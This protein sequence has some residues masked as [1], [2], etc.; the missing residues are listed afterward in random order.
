VA[1]ADA[2]IPQPA[3]SGVV[4]VATPAGPDAG[5]RGAAGTNRPVTAARQVQPLILA[6]V[7]NP[8]AGETGRARN[9]AR[10]PYSTGRSTRSVAQHCED[11]IEA[12][13]TRAYRQL[14]D[15]TAAQDVVIAA[16]ARAAGLPSNPSGVTVSVW[17]VLAAHLHIVGLP[18]DQVV[19]DPEGSDAAGARP[20]GLARQHPAIVAPAVG[21]DRPAWRR[22]ASSSTNHDL[23]GT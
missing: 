14:G 7:P 3:G 20:V 8:A 4:A 11:H 2:T 19:A 13:Y 9:G 23:Q 18:D 15:R 22:A 10:R 16:V 5:I 1:S 6:G 12:L 17:H 21:Q